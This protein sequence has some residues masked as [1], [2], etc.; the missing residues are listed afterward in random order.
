VLAL[1]PE[2]FKDLKEKDIE[3]Y[4]NV[5][6]DIVDLPATDPDVIES[7]YKVDFDEVLWIMMDVYEA[8]YRSHDGS[9]ALSPMSVGRK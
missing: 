5:I 7:I 6:Y 8:K 9:D 4:Q 1:V 2:I 3:F